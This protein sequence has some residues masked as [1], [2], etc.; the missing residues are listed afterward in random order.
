MFENNSPVRA[1]LSR[2]PL[3]TKVWR[4]LRN[5]AGGNQSDESCNHNFQA[6]KSRV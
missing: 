5:G 2:R 1:P 6:C 3:L 4:E